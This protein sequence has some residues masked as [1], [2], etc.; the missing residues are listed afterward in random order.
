YDE[1][2]DW[3]CANQQY[4]TYPCCAPGTAESCTS[5]PQETHIVSSGP[6]NLEDN[7]LPD[8]TNKCPA[9]ETYT[10]TWSMGYCYQGNLQGTP[11]SGGRKTWCYLDL[12]CQ[13]PDLVSC[14][15]QPTCSATAPSVPALLSPANGASVT[16]EIISLVWNDTTQDWGKGGWLLVN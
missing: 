15:C 9:G 13:P 10:G 12:T 1:N 6:Y 7:G 3:F 16:T 14:S 2:G 4:A 11:V 8:L 5:T